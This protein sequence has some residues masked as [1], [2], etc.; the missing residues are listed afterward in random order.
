[1]S[2]KPD[3]LAAFFTLAGEVVPGVTSLVSPRDIRQRAEAAGRAGYVGMGFLADD[4]EA[5]IDRHG[6]ADVR[7]ILGDNGIRHVEIEGISSWLAEGGEKAGAAARHRE[8]LELA[9]KVG[10]RNIKAIG[11]LSGRE[12]PV[13]FMIEA[14]RSVCE[15][16]IGITDALI[17]IELLPMTHLRDL[18]TG[19]AVV[20]GAG[21]ANGGLLVD[22]WHMTRGGI[23]YQDFSGPAKPWIKAV[24]LNDAAAR[25]TGDL[26]ADSF[27]CRRLPGEGDFDVPAFLREIAKAGYAGPYGV[28]IASEEIRHMPLEEAASRSYAATM[29]QFARLAAVP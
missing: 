21:M 11:D 1:M 24:E 6:L 3:L 27:N 20:E 19:T 10:A 12:W 8:V 7:A 26:M 14:F 18:V 4:L 22:I 25:C 13:P 17:T 16:A 29:A 5:A 28:E 2:G 15:E 23:A 9:A